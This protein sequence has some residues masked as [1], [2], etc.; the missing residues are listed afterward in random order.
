MQLRTQFV[1]VS[2]HYVNQ[3]F[4]SKNYSF[5]SSSDL[6]TT[7]RVTQLVMANTPELQDQHIGQI[8]PQVIFVTVLKFFIMHKIQT[9]F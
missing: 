8:V 9:K 5:Q 6:Y 1:Q 2:K 3:Q 7:R 4:G